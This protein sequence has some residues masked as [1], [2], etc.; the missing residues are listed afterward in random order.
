MRESTASIR[1][2]SYET[3]GRM[4]LRKATRE[5]TDNTA[6]GIRNLI[7]Y[8]SVSCVSLYSAHIHL[9]LML[10]GLLRKTKR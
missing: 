10:G 3:P 1:H 9:G 7:I 2:D 6:T 8:K 5:I 4:T